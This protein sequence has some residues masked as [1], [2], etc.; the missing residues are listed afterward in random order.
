MEDGDK[1]KTRPDLPSRPSW[2]VTLP[3]LDWTDLQVEDAKAH[4]MSGGSCLIEGHAGAGKSYFV[5]QCLTELNKSKQCVL[6]AKTHVA[7]NNMI[8]GELVGQT[9]DAFTRR[10]VING[11]FAGVCLAR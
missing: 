7:A 4:I 3:V 2:N 1:T 11:S 8:S 6:L 5:R 9:C 10:H